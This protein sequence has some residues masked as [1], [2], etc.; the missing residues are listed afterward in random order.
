MTNELPEVTIWTD[1]S[2]QPN[3]GRGGWAAVLLYGGY[4]KKEL[5]GAAQHTT[6]NRMELTAVLEGIKALK[7]PCAI[8][9]IT[10]S[11]LVVGW[12]EH[13]WKT[14]NEWCALLVRQ[15]REE[16]TCGR[17]VVEFKK[18]KGHAGR[19]YNERCDEL[20]AQARS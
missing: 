16:I 4:H 20:A 11:A 18:V 12:L 8:T 6:S 19:Y 2:A 9:V 10:D 14:K 7:R 1:G 3:P 5:S 15:I 13:D 17:H